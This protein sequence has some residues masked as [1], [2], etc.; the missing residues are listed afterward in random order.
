MLFALI[1]TKF[2]AQMIK[3]QSLQFWLMF[4]ENEIQTILKENGNRATADVTS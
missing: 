1:G 3:M 4:A 2:V